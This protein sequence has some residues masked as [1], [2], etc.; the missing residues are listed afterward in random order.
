MKTP[1]I[2]LHAD[3][4]RKTSEKTPQIWTGITIVRLQ[5]RRLS[6]RSRLHHSPA[7]MTD[8]GPKLA[9]G[10]FG[11]GVKRKAGTNSS[12]TATSYLLP[13]QQPLSQS[14]K[15]R[16][17]F[18]I[19]AIPNQP[20]PVAPPQKVAIPRLRRGSDVASN[21][22]STRAGDKHRISHA[23]EPC[24]HRKTKCSGERPTCKHCEDF[25]IVCLYADGK[26]DR[27]KK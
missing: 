14:Q 22:G 21:A 13:G 25:K 23:C 8:H 2:R 15:P 10:D 3:S 4:I 24:R 5:V 16:G 7:E 19:P 11:Q 26:R 27:V 17:T 20:G 9:N 6:R 12:S 18:Q 1:P